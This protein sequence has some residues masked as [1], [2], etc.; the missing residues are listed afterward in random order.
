M[1]TKLTTKTINQQTTAEKIVTV[2]QITADPVVTTYTE[3]QIDAEIAKATRMIANF[4]TQLDK[5][6]SLKAQFNQ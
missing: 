5:W 3:A 6:T 4:Q 2:I 1:E